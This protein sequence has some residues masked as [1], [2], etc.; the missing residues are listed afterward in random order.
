MNRGFKFY[1]DRQSKA[2]KLTRVPTTQ[3]ITT[4]MFSWSRN[5]LYLG[6]VIVFIGLGALLNSL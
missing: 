4:G 6:V 2:R 5:P 3:L 1:R